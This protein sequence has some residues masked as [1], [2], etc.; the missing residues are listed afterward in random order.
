MNYITEAIEYLTHYKELDIANDN[1]KLRIKEVEG[2]LESCKGAIYSDMPK[3]SKTMPDD[4]ICNLIF[5]RD[6]LKEIQEENKLK[7][8]TI[9]SMF[10]KLEDEYKNILT[11]SYVE[12][13]NEMAILDELNMSRATYYR[14]RSK[15]IK[16]FAIQ[17]FGIVAIK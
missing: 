14:I 11:I 12:R 9:E 3:G 17:L 10:N 13:K 16:S 2:E 7:L 8:N 1:I 5:Q 15:A 6:R 4:R